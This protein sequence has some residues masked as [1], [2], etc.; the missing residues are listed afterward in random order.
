MA[1]FGP[2]FLRSAVTALCCLLPA[3][4]AQAMCDVIP[5]VTQE[6]RGALGSVNRPFAIPNDDGEEILVRLRPVCEPES[7]GFADLQGGLAPEDDYF[8]T[9]LFEPGFEQVVFD[10]HAAEDVA[11]GER[12]AVV[13]V[14]R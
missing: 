1:R 11:V 2:R 10:G 13:A 5:G 7:A 6:F 8:V 14:V 9:V 12:A 4:A 3:V